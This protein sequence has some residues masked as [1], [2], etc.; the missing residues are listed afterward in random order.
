[1]TQPSL[2]LTQ[3]PYHPQFSFMLFD[4]FS[5]VFELF[6][7]FNFASIVSDTFNKAI[8]EKVLTNYKGALKKNKAVKSNVEVATESSQ[9][10]VQHPHVKL[11]SDNLLN[12]TLEN[13]KTLCDEYEKIDKEVQETKNIKSIKFIPLLSSYCGLYCIVLLL[14]AGFCNE[15]T[16][17]Y[18][19]WNS[20]GIINILSI[21]F[22]TTVAFIKDPDIPYPIVML[23]FFIVFIIG[24]GFYYIPNKIF[25]YETNHESLSIFIV[26]ESLFVPIYHYLLFIVRGSYKAMVKNNNLIGKLNDFQVRFDTL[27]STVDQINQ[28]LQNSYILKPEVI[29]AVTT[30]P[31][32]S[33]SKPSKNASRSRR[34]KSK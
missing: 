17:S 30:T 5:S 29:V 12:P 19:F 25:F 28:T 7:A 8:E 33:S 24:I 1:M 15:S 31:T 32:G 26:C 10:I 20:I 6:G 9:S 22:I 27:K 23:I 13:L 3:F 11:I 21:I 34:G 2:L 14:I 16:C 18:S 4:R